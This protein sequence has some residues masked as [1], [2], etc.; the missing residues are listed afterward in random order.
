MG[1]GQREKVPSRLHTVSTE[2]D[3]RLKLRNLSQ[4]QESDVQWTEPPRQPAFFF[5]IYRDGI[6][7]H[8][9]AC[10]VFVNVYAHT[11]VVIECSWMV[12]SGTQGL[13]CGW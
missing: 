7:P 13:Q 4:N 6:D 9:R 10:F 2:P 1:S 8:K 5:L 3:A 12:K 11:N